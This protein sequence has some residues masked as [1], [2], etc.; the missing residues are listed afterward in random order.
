MPDKPRSFKEVVAAQ[1]PA[2]RARV[3][4]QNEGVAA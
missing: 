3:Q 2:G 4:M 1:D